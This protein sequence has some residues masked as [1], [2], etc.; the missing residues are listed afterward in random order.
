[1]KMFYKTVPLTLIAC[2]QIGFIAYKKRVLQFSM[3]GFIYFG[4]G[5][6]IPKNYENSAVSF[7]VSV[8]LSF[9]M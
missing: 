6:S 2:S 4:L 1:M 7:G 8:C 3:F 9:S 5:A